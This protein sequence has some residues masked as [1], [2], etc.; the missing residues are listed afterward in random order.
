MTEVYNNILTAMCKVVSNKYIWASQL[1]PRNGRQSIRASF[2]LN[3][4]RLKTFY[5]YVK[6]RIKILFNHNFFKTHR[7]KCTLIKQSYCSDLK[8]LLP[9]WN[10]KVQH[11]PPLFP[12]V[13]PDQ[14]IFNQRK[15][16]LN[17]LNMYS[18]V[19]K[20]SNARL[21]EDWVGGSDR[22]ILEV[23]VWKNHLRSKISVTI[24]S[25]L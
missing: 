17:S 5:F 3:Y 9:I 23:L 12:F 11:S 14:I 4:L 8:S 15:S 20:N 19:F 10:F 1:L 6:L 21:T 25:I 2:V 24:L 7:R 13:T 22:C 16:L 18:L